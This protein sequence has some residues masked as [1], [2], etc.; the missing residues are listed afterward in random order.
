M[1]NLLIILAFIVLSGLSSW[2]KKR[3]QG[4]EAEPRP[5]TERPAPRIPQG[6]AARPQSPPVPQQP[7][8]QPRFDWE[9]ELRRLLEGESPEAPAA[10][11]RV[12]PPII[13]EE[14]RPTPLVVRPMPEREPR[15]PQTPLSPPT[16]RP[17][18]EPEVVP[19]VVLVSTPSAPPALEAKYRAQSAE[20]ILNELSRPTTHGVAPSP[21]IANA[22]SLLRS[23][24]TARQAIIASLV[25]G[26]PK[27]LE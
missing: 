23:S 24:R 8:K 10:P 9:A 22:L 17:T 11:P 27:A 20:Y 7:P 15:S 2:L 13:V 21:E 12:P 1:E 25:F 4:E 6:G 26:P 19:T 18:V 3:G 5:G 14:Q 16:I